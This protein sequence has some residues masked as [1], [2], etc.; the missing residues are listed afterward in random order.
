MNT[1]SFNTDCS[2]DENDNIDVQLNGLEKF[3]RLHKSK[4]KDWEIDTV[5]PYFA[6]DWDFYIEMRSWGVKSFG[7]YATKVTR[8]EVWI[9]YYVGSAFD[10]ETNDIEFDLLKE[11]QEFDIETETLPNNNYE[12]KEMFCPNM[13]D[14]DFN[15]KKITVYF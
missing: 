14:I 8:F 5:T 3:L 1:T 4:W 10:D 9:D 2:R 15:D 13:V 7:V 12:V 11:I 6:F